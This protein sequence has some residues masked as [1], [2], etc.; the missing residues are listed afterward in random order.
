[1]A[2]L[3]CDAQQQRHILWLQLLRRDVVLQCFRCLEGAVKAIAK[4]HEFIR[5]LRMACRVVEQQGC[6]DQ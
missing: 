4:T 5:G 2:I 1:M 6:D 3:P